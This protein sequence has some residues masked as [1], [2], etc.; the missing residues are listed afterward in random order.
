MLKAIMFDLDDTLL[1]DKRS[2]E[3]A[4]KATCLTAAKIYNIDPGLLEEKVRQQARELYAGYE[5]YSF[6]K[7]IGINPFEGLWGEFTED[8]ENFRKMNKLMPT[9]RKQAWTKGLE[10]VGIDDPDLGVQLAEQFPQERKNSPFTYEETFPVLDQLH[11]KYQLLLLTNGS[12]DLQQSKLKLTPEIAPYFDHIVISG[13]FGS[14]KPDPTIFEHALKLLSL[15]KNEV[16]MVGDNLLTDI[17]GASRAG[18]K[19][20]WINRH[21][22]ETDE[23]VPDYEISHLDELGG[24]LAKL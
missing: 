8:E 17:L 13:Q 9:Y 16:I 4:F 1:W 10:A 3:E 23:V 2:V 7:N 6:T 14:G 24:V 15:D 20:V 11:G 19:S 5:T 21:G 12:P 22:K 18:I